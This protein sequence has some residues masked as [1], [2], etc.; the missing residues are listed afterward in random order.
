MDTTPPHPDPRAAFLSD[1]EILEILRKAVG[2]IVKKAE[3][4]DIVQSALVGAL[5]DPNYP[6]E[7]PA[8]VAWLLTKGR[9]RAIDHLRKTKRHGRVVGEAPE[10][11]VDEMRPASAAV[12]G[13]S[14]GHDILEAA[15]FTQM[16]LAEQASNPATAASVQWLLMHLRG[17]AYD[18]ISAQEGVRAETVRQSVAR[19][20]RRLHAAWLTAAAAVI[21]FF[22]ARAL[23]KR[24]PP[25]E[26][27]HPTPSAS[28]APPLVPALSTVPSER[29]APS[30]APAP[31]ASPPENVQDAA[32]EFR[33][34]AARQCKAKKWIE[35]LEDLR[36]AEEIDP[37]GAL[38]PEIV[39]MESDARMHL[40]S[41]D[42]KP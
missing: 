8:F 9:S 1:P 33:R 41:R 35:C 22:V 28:G 27:A 10:G 25:E 37:A 31:S 12:D 15:R 17:V 4:D 23:L 36:R 3:V 6:A 34:D 29:P 38:D 42:G 20:K 26:I 24:K 32:R 18:E 30:A 2:K 11:E 40:P 5:S 19:M 16:R 7:R 13:A 21:L 14:R 39:K